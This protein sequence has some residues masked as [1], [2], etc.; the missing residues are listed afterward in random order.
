MFVECLHRTAPTVLCGV[1]LTTTPSDRGVGF[2]LCTPDQYGTNERVD[3]DGVGVT[4]VGGLPHRDCGRSIPRRPFCGNTAWSGADLALG[5]SPHGG[6]YTGQN[7][8][9]DPKRVE[10][11][12]PGSDTDSLF[13][14]CQATVSSRPRCRTHVAS[15]LQANS[16][17]WVDTTSKQI[18][19]SAFLKTVIDYKHLT[20]EFHHAIYQ[21]IVH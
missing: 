7:I 6:A 20:L 21:S 4:R 15:Q 1:L 3:L 16:V 14:V 9:C 10:H 2:A 5:R 17:K 18:P 12:G 8:D 11:N 19:A 13:R